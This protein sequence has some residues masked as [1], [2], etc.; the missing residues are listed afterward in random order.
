MRGDPS[1]SPI[2]RMGAP[3]VQPDPDR[4]FARIW[5]WCRDFWVEQGTIAVKPD[6]LPE[7]LRGPM[8]AWADETYGER[9]R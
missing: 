3:S 8:V 2:Y 1:I 4:V 7:E 5:R 6:E 9:R